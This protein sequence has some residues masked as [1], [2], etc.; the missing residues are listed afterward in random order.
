MSDERNNVIPLSRP[1]RSDPSVKLEYRHIPRGEPV[2]GKTMQQ[3]VDAIEDY[4]FESEG[5]PLFNCVEYVELRR[6][7][8]IEG[9]K[10]KPANDPT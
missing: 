3:L 10:P 5:C 9:L 4:G 1:F 8:D 6:R 7:I 2:E